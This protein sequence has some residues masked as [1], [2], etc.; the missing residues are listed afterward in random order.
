MKNLSEKEVKSFQKLFLSTKRGGE[1]RKR[2]LFEA[3]LNSK[4]AS[5][6]KRFVRNQQYSRQNY[7]QLSKRLRE[8]LFDFLMSFHLPGK[9]DERFCEE[10]VCFKKLYFLKVLLD[11]GMQD[12]AQQV[13]V[14]VIT[15]AE[16]GHL[17]MVYCEAIDLQNRYFPLRERE[18]TSQSNIHFKR[19]KADL[20]LNEYLRQYLVESITHAHDSDGGLRRNMITL[21]NQRL[22]PIEDNHFIYELHEINSLFHQRLFEIAYLRLKNLQEQFG[23]SGIQ[24][25][26]ALGLVYLELAKASI[27]LRNYDQ[28]REYLLQAQ[29]NLNH[30]RPWLAIIYDLKFIIALRSA[31]TKEQQ[32]ILN[33]ANVELVSSSKERYE[34]KWEFYSAYY[35]YQKGDLKEVIKLANSKAAGLLKDERE[36]ILLKIL[37]LICIYRLHD[38]DWFFYKSECLRKQIT[39]KISDSDR[40]QMFFSV[41]RKPFDLGKNENMLK[42]LVMLEDITPWHPLSKELLNLSGILSSLI[43]VFDT[44]YIADNA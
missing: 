38:Q 33:N 19:L 8:N 23:N 5:D 11:R 44:E 25:E 22:L 40:L 14:E 41:F 18:A 35:Y 43:S 42:K 10:M 12:H 37:E 36:L 30:T 15:A 7:Y 32:A 27:C 4:R 2:Q 31:N 34:G 29:K 13:L 16:K 1:N 17:S 3:A 26:S 24:S 20:A 21:V 9:D 39:S 28:G 6:F